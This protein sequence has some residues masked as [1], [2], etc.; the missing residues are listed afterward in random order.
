MGSRARIAR[1]GLYAA[2]IAIVMLGVA[3]TTLLPVWDVWQTPVAL[4]AFAVLAEWYR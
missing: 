2:G 1:G 3:A 4:A